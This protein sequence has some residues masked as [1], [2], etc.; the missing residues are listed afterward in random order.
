[1]LINEN[2]KNIGEGGIQ[3]LPQRRPLYKI[4]ST[5]LQSEFIE[6]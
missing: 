5:I 3:K 6:K 1:M 2:A 4:F